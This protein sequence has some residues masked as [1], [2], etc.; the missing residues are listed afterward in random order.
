MKPKISVVIPCFN[1]EKYIAIAIDSV[2]AQNYSNY[3]LIVVD[4][5]STDNS[6]AIIEQ[7]SDRL[8]IILHDVN[9]GHGAA[10]NSGFSACN[11]DI[12]TL[13]DADDFLLPNA[14]NIIASN[15]NDTFAMYHYF[16]NLVDDKGVYI[17]IFPKK[18]KGLDS[19]DLKHSLLTN[20]YINTTVTS[21]LSFSRA[22]LFSVLPIDESLFRQGGDGFLVSI[23]PLY[24]QVCTI[25]DQLSAYR[26]HNT[27]HS[28]FS[29]QLIKR[30][31]WVVQH[32]NYCLDAIIYHASK[33]SL[34][35]KRSLGKNNFSLLEQLMI[36]HVSKLSIDDRFF[37]KK[38]QI[39]FNGIISLNKSSLPFFKKL[40]LNIWWFFVYISPDNFSVK[41]LSW[42]LM[43]STRPLFLTKAI[44]FFK[45][46]KQ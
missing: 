19:G 32:T 36:L 28:S 26:Q 39:F 27:N 15:Y 10:F 12:V 17:D 20:G 30:A 13:L 16:S 5:L 37:S 40:S 33:M 29:N 45:V 4:D 46:V 42:K 25:N 22:F 18:S 2:L 7:Y 35:T 1:Y 41:L 6:R 38:Y 44:N 9:K 8:N 34:S 23:A 24:G 14:L 3:E 43:S 11:G 31:L 21:G